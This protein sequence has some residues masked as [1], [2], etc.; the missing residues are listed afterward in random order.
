MARKQETDAQRGDRKRRMNY[1]LGWD[2][3]R[4]SWCTDLLFVGL[5]RRARRRAPPIGIAFEGM[6]DY[7]K[8]RNFQTW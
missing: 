8:L 7:P 4:A 6:G 1:V 5:F 2:H 3:R